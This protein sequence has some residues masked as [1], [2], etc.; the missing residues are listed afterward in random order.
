MKKL[1]YTINNKKIN[2]YHFNTINS[3][4]IYAKSQIQNFAPNEINIFSADVQTNGIGQHNREWRSSNEPLDLTATYGFLLDKKFTKSRNLIPH[5]AVCSVVDLLLSE[6]IESK[7]K[8]VNDVLIDKKKI[9]GVLTESL[10]DVSNLLYNGYDGVFVGIGLNVNSSFDFIGTLKNNS[11]SM[12]IEAKKN[13]PEVKKNFDVEQLLMKLTSIFLNNLDELFSSG[14]DKFRNKINSKLER[15]DNQNVLF[16]KMDGNDYVGR[17]KEI[18]EGGDL[19]MVDENGE[20][21]SFIGGRLQY[22]V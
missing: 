11:T 21:E 22:C 3:T 16:K 18:G 20:I 4:Q 6:K 19:I 5:V 7:I 8:W 9:C 1:Q 2:H 17:I 15:F 13:Q 12:K 14:F 10:S